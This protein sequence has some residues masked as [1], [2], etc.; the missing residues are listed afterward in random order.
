WVGLTF[1]ATCTG[2]SAAAPLKL[3]IW[4]TAS[5]TL[6]IAGVLG[7]GAACTLLNTADF[8]TVDVAAATTFTTTLAVPG[9]PALAGFGLYLQVGELD[10][11][12]GNLAVSNGVGL[13]IGG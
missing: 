13:V 6:P 8:V 10:V 9:D 1:S 4:G 7:A 12:A 2:M 5:T 11:T 3:S